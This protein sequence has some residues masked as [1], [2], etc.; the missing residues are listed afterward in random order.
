LNESLGTSD[1]YFR[2]LR[3]LSLSVVLISFILVPFFLFAT[4]TETLVFA[5]LDEAESGVVVAAVA[6]SA[7]AL[8]VFL[9]IPSSIIST[10]CGS[11]LGVTMGA[12]VSG[13]GMSLSCLLGWYFGR[14]VGRAGA[15]QL[16]GERELRRM[17]QLFIRRGLAAVVICRPVPVAAEA[18]IILAGMSGAALGRLML[19]STLSNLGISL[20]YATAGALAWE[21]QS[22]FYALIAAICF[23]VLCLCLYRLCIRMMKL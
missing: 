20:V 15:E 4:A 21:S 22:F 6:V 1:K 23:P 17:E 8:D 16:V 18:S 14:R 12:L 10:I 9:P 11:A 3:W 5:F 7:L 19:V 2:L 13:L